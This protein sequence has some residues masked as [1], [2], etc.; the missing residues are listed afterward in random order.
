MTNKIK[1]NKPIIHIFLLIF[2]SFI[3]F[4]LIFLSS[5]TNNINS[6]INFEKSIQIDYLPDY[7]SN[8]IVLG[9]LELK[10]T[11][12]LPS[13]IKLDNY[14]LCQISSNYGSQTYELNYIGDKTSRDFDIFSNYNNNYIEISSKDS[15][16]LNI[17]YKYIYRLN[18]Y[19]K[20]HNLNG[21]E[22]KFYLFKVQNDDDT[23]NYC[24]QVSKE[25]AFSQIKVTI[26]LS[27][28]ELSSINKIKPINDEKIY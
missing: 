15:V 23:Y 17:V 26:N 16:K 11:G 22:L 21:S 8:N 2:M 3:F 24:D 13:K 10:N 18:S 28:E 14:V 4:S 5:S 1:K 7:N 20:R 12:L 9:T 25:N 6:T 27:E 19:V